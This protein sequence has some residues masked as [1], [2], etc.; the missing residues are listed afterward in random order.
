MVSVRQLLKAPSVELSTYIGRCGQVILVGSRHR[1]LIKDT[2]LVVKSA[3]CRFLKRHSISD[4]DLFLFVMSCVCQRDLLPSLFCTDRFSPYEPLDGQ[5]K[6]VWL[7]CRSI[8]EMH[9]SRAESVF[10]ALNARLPQ[11]MAAC[12]FLALCMRTPFALALFLHRSDQL[13]ELTVAGA[14]LGCI[15][16]VRR[17]PVVSVVSRSVVGTNEMFEDG[18]CRC[19]KSC[20]EQTTAPPTSQVGVVPSG[21]GFQSALVEELAYLNTTDHCLG[22]ERLVQQARQHFINPNDASSAEAWA[23]VWENISLTAEMSYRV[24]QRRGTTAFVVVWLHTNKRFVCFARQLTT[25]SNYD[26]W[27]VTCARDIEASVRTSFERY[28]HRLCAPVSR[29][30]MRYAFYIR[31]RDDRWQIK[32]CDDTSR[33]AMKAINKARAEPERTCFMMAQ[34]SFRSVLSVCFLSFR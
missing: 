31:D 23:S 33:V 19:I 26:G 13:G 32:S 14:A 22:W 29:S 27:R 11:C 20:M 7:L 34:G 25:T 5:D 10:D 16:P 9:A 18:I 28:G 1:E 12:G 2:A 21:P 8:F 24:L 15:D 3:A 4:V 6:Q 30:A 17:R